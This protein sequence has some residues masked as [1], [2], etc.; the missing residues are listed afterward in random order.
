[1]RW[2]RRTR[3][4]RS[5]R[6]RPGLRDLGGRASWPG[7][8]RRPC[9]STTGS[10]WSP[11]RA[12]GGGAGAT[13]RATSTRLR[14][15]QR[16]SQDEGVNLAGIK[17]IRELEDAG[18]GAARRVAELEAVTLT[19]R[20]RARSRSRRRSRR[21]PRRCRRLRPATAATC[22]RP[23]PATFTTA[24][25]VWKPQG[26][27]SVRRLRGVP[28]PSSVGP[29]AR[30][31]RAKHAQLNVG[32]SIS[33][34]FHRGFAEADHQE[35]G[36]PE[37]PRSARPPAAG[38]PQV[39]PVHLL[40]ALLGQPEGTARPL[41]E[42]VGVDRP[43]SARRPQPPPSACRRPAARRSR[44]PPWPAAPLNALNAAGD[45]ARKLDDEYVSTEHLLVGLARAATSTADLLKKAGATPQALREAFGKVRG[46]ARVTSQ[47]PEATY[48]ALEKYGVDLTAAARDGKLDPVIGR[49]AEIRRVV[50]VLSRRTKNNPVLIGEPGVGKTAVVEGLAQ[51]IVAGDVPESA[52]RQAPGVPGPG[53]DG[54]RRE[55]PR[56]VRGA[57][58]GR[59]G[60]DQGLRRPGR[61][62]HRRA[63]HRGRRG[64]DRRLVDGRRQHAQA[65]AG[66]RRAAD[67]RRDHAGRVP[68]AHREGPGAGAP[69]P[70]GAGRRADAS[71]TPS[72][73]CAGSRAATRRTT[74]CRSP[75]PR[76]SPRPRCP[77]A[78]SPPAS[79]RTRP[80]T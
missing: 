51:R 59:P 67:G 50:Q 24:L 78:T 34:R 80:S 68:R 74:R 17:R 61:H 29:L 73:S 30:R 33:W 76:W 60:R 27:V 6:R 70:A 46:S 3:S 22:C 7:C 16:L 69:L 39:E 11:G 66:P 21:R 1:M 56:R 20:P 79:C 9:G 23:C 19:R 57:P 13:P 14:E 18:R 12:T 38:N 71:R 42:A 36:G 52:A 5:P 55:V 62:L 58:Q 48:Q 31:A 49:D 8:T 40:L 44:R 75:T 47:D 2:H 32:G 41:L 45:E 54:G 35:P 25:A 53:R 4:G 15:V 43:R 72:R 26:N 63:A 37:P 77:T 10:A 64:R 65:D 28:D